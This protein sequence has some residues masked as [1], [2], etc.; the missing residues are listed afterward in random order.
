MESR[1]ICRAAIE[2]QTHRTDLWTQCGGEGGM[3]GE[4]SMEIYTL[5]YV[6]QIA[7]GNLLCSTRNSTLLLISCIS[8]VHVLQLLNQHW[9]SIIK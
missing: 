3:N 7:S 6:K 2:M 1:K 5:P 8:E 4:S 9:H